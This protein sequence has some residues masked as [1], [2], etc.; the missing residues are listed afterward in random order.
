MSRVCERCRAKIP[1]T[2]SEQVALLA[3]WRTDLGLLDD[4]DEDTISHARPPH[5]EV[6][7][8]SLRGDPRFEKIVAAPGTEV[9][10]AAS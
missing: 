3:F 10:I 8:D 9:V 2:Q 7:W 1:I 6:S 4:E 5:N